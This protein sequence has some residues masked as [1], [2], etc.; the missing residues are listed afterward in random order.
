M[1]LYETRFGTDPYKSYYAD[2]SFFFFFL[3]NGVLQIARTNLNNN[4]ECSR[5]IR[6]F[7]YKPS[8]FIFK[9]QYYFAGTEAV[10]I[11]VIF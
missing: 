6:R 3:F 4:I 11:S 1:Y 9:F 7:F 10:Q 2:V 8:V 5:T